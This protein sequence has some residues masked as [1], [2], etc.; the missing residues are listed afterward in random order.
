MAEASTVDE[1]L[2]EFPEDVRAVLERVRETVR[3]AV[4]DGVE[5]IS[6]QVPT[7]RVDGRA[8]VYFAGW[9]SHVSVYPIPQGDNDFDAAIAPYQ[10]GKGTLK[11]PL[12]KPIPYELIG[13]VAALL[14]QQ[15][16]H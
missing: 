13:R 16:G 2:A 8:V 5:D 11:F 14:A 4:P 3:A 12:N 15:R 6:Y 9:K 7:L 10:A 1:Y